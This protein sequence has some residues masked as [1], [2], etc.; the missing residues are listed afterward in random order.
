MN[1]I[2]KKEY[3]KQILEAVAF[4]NQKK[5]PDALLKFTHLTTINPKNLKIHE[6]LVYLHLEM[7]NILEAKSELAIYKKL[8]HE[9]TG[10]DT[11]D[12][13]QSLE[14]YLADSGS[15][16]TLSKECDA[17]ILAKESSDIDKDVNSVLNLA[18]LYISQNRFDE[19]DKLI[20]GYKEQFLAITGLSDFEK[21]PEVSA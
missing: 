15:E 14:D 16:E 8:L 18:I 1:V 21:T 9:A 11:E 17:I 20:S 4:F 2:N 3:D 19:A 10:I 6:L 7:K 13:Q 12:P 5:Y